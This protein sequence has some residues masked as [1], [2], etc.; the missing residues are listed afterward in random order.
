MMNPSPLLSL[1]VPVLNEAES[2][3]AFYETVMPVLEAIDPAWEIVFI[4]DGSTDDTA[5]QIK[6]LHENDARIKLLSFSRNFGKEAA[7]SAGLET[8][9]GEAVIP[10]D[11]DLQDPPELIPVMVEQWR[12]G[13]QVVLATRSA[14]KDDALAKRITAQWFYQLMQ[15]LSETPIPPNVG[16]FRLMD[17]CVVEAI[18]QMPERTRFMKGILSWAGYSTTQ[19]YYDRPSR[20]A[21]TTKFRFRNLWKLALDGVFSF[22]T[23]PLKV[24]TYL[25]AFISLA[26]F[27][28]AG[29][30]IIKTLMF[31]VD[32]QG[33]ASL[34]TVI[35]FLGGIQ[36]MSLGILGEY[37]GRIYHETKRRP[38]YLIAERVGFEGH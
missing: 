10:M 35:L 33:Y 29:I 14:R 22:S 23:L 16:D 20:Q 15:R 32:T 3:S 2:L 30:I 18:R 19:V 31:G 6:R 8:A 11:V 38:L 26:A 13:Y 36:L 24:W 21:G 34:M 9:E 37:I 1:I 12:L 25:G 4:D 27:V 28:Y 7:L 17:R 5:N